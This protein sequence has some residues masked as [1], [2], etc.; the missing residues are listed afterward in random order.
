[1]GTESSAVTMVGA[2]DSRGVRTAGMRVLFIAPY[3]PQRDGIGAYSSRLAAALQRDGHEIGIIT[4]RPLH[5]AE[6][7]D[8]QNATAPTVIGDLGAHRRQPKYLSRVISDWSPKVIH[9]QFGV[10]AFGGRLPALLR[11]LERAPSPVVLTAHE[12]TRDLDRTGPIGRFLYGHLASKASLTIV[13]TQGAASAIRS[14]GG[15]VRVKVLP[16]PALPAPRQVTSPDELRHRFGIE[17]RDV[18]LAF[19]FVHPH[20]GLD[21]LVAAFSKARTGSTARQ[22][23]TPSGEAAGLQKF[24][25]VVAGEVRRRSGPFR[26]MELP[27]HLHLRSLRSAVRKGGLEANTVFTGYVPDDDV[28]A[29]FALARAVVLPYRHI[30]QSGVLGLARALGAPLIVSDAGG[31]GERIGG[32]WRYRAG[33]RE[34][35]SQLL[36]RLEIEQPDVLSASGFD[37]TAFARETSASYLEIAQ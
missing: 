32:G 20:K 34:A 33:D 23:G 35:L 24:V 31:F 10:A 4:P 12:V 1:M 30:E 37:L 22:G 19:G 15:E 16:F 9:V 8:G 3:P 18:L 28:A 7:S 36:E 2:H 26:L 17:G 6:R 5:R 14:L 27:D 29:W 11:L 13:H 25:L 21:D